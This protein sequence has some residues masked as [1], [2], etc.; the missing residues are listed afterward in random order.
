MGH[1]FFSLEWR[2]VNNTNLRFCHSPSDPALALDSHSWPFCLS[3][4]CH[5]SRRG[6]QNWHS[7]YWPSLLWSYILFEWIMIISIH[8]VSWPSYHDNMISLVKIN[9]KLPQV[10]DDSSRRCIW[11]KNACDFIYQVFLE[12][13]SNFAH[14]Y[15]QVITSCFSDFLSSQ[16]V[17]LLS[18]PYASRNPWFA[19]QRPVHWICSLA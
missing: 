13:G 6:L 15:F 1:E 18:C 7:C 5:A 11:L 4:A 10:H 8:A 9:T 3:K 19:D 2:G 12:H 16:Q 17:V 14:D